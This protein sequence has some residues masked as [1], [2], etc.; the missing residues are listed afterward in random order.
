MTHRILILAVNLSEGMAVRST[1][2]RIATLTARA[3]VAGMF[4][5][6]SLLW[7]LGAVTGDT[8]AL[9]SAV[10]L[11]V[12]PLSIALVAYA[13]DRHTTVLE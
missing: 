2:R 5:L 6:A 10:V 9:A 12:V 3:I 1:S 7:I 13:L 4:L 11:T 8:A